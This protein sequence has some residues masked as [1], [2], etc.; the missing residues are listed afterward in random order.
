MERDHGALRELINDCTVPVFGVNAEGKVDEWNPMS[1]QLFGYKAED[2]IGQDFLNTLIPMGEARVSLQ[3]VLMIL[4]P[5]QPM[6]RSQLCCN[7]QEYVESIIRTV[8]QDMIHHDSI[9]MV[10]LLLVN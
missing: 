6:L 9:C 10:N 3:R 8:S 4:T 2:I 5:C 7:L 1:E